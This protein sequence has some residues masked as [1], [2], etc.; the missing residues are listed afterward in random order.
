VAVLVVGQ[1]LARQI[2]LDATDYPV[3]RSLG[4]TRRQLAG[5]AVARCAVIGLVGATLT[6]VGAIALSPVTPIGLARVAEP[7]PGLAVDTVIV[8][9]GAAGTALLPA[10]LALWPAWRAAQASSP[11]FRAGLARRPRRRF[12][13]ADLIARAGFPVTLT[14]GVRLALERGHGPT[15]VPVRTTIG[16]AVV[17]L[18]ALAASLTFGA[19]LTHLV[20]SPP[21][22]GV[23]WDTEILNNNGPGSVPE[24]VAVARSDPDVA[25]AA[26]IQTGLSFRLNGLD[27]PGFAFAPVKGTFAA[28]VL[29]GRTPVAADE[30]ALGASTAMRLGARVGTTLLGHAENDGAPRVRVRVAGIVVL[31]PGDAR[32]HLGDGVMATRQALLRLAGGH[33]RSPYVIAVAF[34]PGAD[35]AAAESP[36]DGR[37]SAADE[38][39]FCG[40][41]PPWYYA[42]I[43]AWSWPGRIGR[44][45]RT[46]SL[47]QEAA[48]AAVGAAGGIMLAGRL[49]L[50]VRGPRPEERRTRNPQVEGIKVPPEGFEPSHLA[51][52]ATGLH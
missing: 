10:V 21:L 44:R 8:A 33:A 39:F 18:G 15:S 43:D 49:G 30:V 37:L 1:V 27:L 29:A 46:A 3:L 42:S 2:A 7:S 52:E 12:A 5:I 50:G 13:V 4:L 45:G 47:L 35:T 26:F 16:V 11:A 36:L 32:T 17:G 40:L 38:N 9:I 28:S 34:Q 23:T 20:G 6:V 48:E 24:G 51:P 19:S 25:A 31:P 22:Y 14:A 41:T